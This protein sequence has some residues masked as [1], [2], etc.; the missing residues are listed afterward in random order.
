MDGLKVNIIL[1]VTDKDKK[2]SMLQQLIVALMKGLSSN[3][4]DIIEKI[5]AL[6][7]AVYKWTTLE[8]NPAKAALDENSN[9]SENRGAKLLGDGG[10]GLADSY[11]HIS[12]IVALNSVV[13]MVDLMKFPG[14]LVPCSSKV[15]FMSRIFVLGESDSAENDSCDLPLEP[16]SPLS[17]VLDRVD[18]DSSEHDETLKSLYK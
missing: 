13:L 12:V 4:A 17:S 1:I 6:V 3:L 2:L 7:Y 9:G 5:A 16:N 10:I 18:M 11:K 8:S 14:K 15:I